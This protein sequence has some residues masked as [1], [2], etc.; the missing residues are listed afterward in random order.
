VHR[1]CGGQKRIG[2]LSRATNLTS[3]SLTMTGGIHRGWERVGKSALTTSTNTCNPGARRWRSGRDRLKVQL[4]P[5]HE[6][7][8]LSGL[9]RGT[10]TRTD[11][12]RGAKGGGGMGEQGG[13]QRGASAACAHRTT[14]FSMPKTV[15]LTAMFRLHHGLVAPSLTSPRRDLDWEIAMLTSFPTRALG[16]SWGQGRLRTGRGKEENDPGTGMGAHPSHAAVSPRSPSSVRTPSS[17]Q[18]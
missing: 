9:H 5:R 8:L 16:P 15:P 13:K 4:L 12:G 6:V 3:F 7:G 10:H 1:A 11:V 2:T 17:P 14:P 18:V